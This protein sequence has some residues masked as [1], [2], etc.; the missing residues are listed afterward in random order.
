MAFPAS[1]NVDG[2]NPGPNSA[3]LPDTVQMPTGNIWK[4]GIF[5]INI[6]PA[7]MGT[8]GS[9]EQTF[10]TTGIGLLTTDVVLVQKAAAQ[11]GLA[12]GGSR[13]SAADT[14][15]ITYINGTAVSITPTANEAYKVTVLRIQP[16]W[17]APATGNQLD[18]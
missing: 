7:V 17:T 2:S 15:A 10:A 13:V 16:N 12:I 4:V 14:L 6:T 3:A 11:A 5:T 1:T 8:G 18:W 9:A